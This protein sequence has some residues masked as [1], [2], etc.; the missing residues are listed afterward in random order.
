L[1]SLPAALDFSLE[2][3]L[4]VRLRAMQGNDAEAFDQGEDIGER[5]DP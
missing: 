2:R 4:R 5:L 3:R 1:V